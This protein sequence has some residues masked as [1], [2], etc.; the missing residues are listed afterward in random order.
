MSEDEQR[1]LHEQA[2]QLAYTAI[3]LADL[4]PLLTCDEWDALADETGRRVVAMILERINNRRNELE[5]STKE[6]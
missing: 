6:T 2:S 3:R 4:S 1:D 5:T